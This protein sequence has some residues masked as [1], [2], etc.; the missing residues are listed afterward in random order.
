MATPPPRSRPETEDRDRGFDHMLPH[1]GGT[2]GAEGA[3]MRNALFVIFFTVGCSSGPMTESVSEL[4]QRADSVNDCCEVAKASLGRED[5]LVKLG[6]RVVLLHDWIA[7]QGSP[8]EYVGFSVTVSNGASM[9]YLVKGGTQAYAGNA[10][11]F[12]VIDG[13]SISKVNFCSEC[14]NPDG[15]EGG[16]GGGGGCTNPD[17][18]PSPGTGTGPGPLL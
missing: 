16:G 11:Q 2:E 1:A 9:S 18:C 13:H 4:E 7:K 6:S 8:G 10:G 5:H 14:D 17:G 12:K 15:C 3:G